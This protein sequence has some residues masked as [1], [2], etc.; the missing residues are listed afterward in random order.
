MFVIPNY[1]ES[2]FNSFFNGCNVM[3][4]IKREGRQTTPVFRPYRKLRHKL[5]FLGIKLTI[6]FSQDRTYLHSAFCIHPNKCT[7]NYQ[8]IIF[9]PGLRKFQLKKGERTADR[10]CVHTKKGMPSIAHMEAHQRKRSIDFQFIISKHLLHNNLSNQYLS[11][12]S[13]VSLS[14]INI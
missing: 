5:S 3:L 10:I 6:S 7:V 8:I 4:H 1:T 11:K 14:Y 9:G 12:S 13:P 2:I